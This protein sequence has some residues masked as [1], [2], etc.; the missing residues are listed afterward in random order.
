MAE[1][2]QVRAPSGLI[3]RAETSPFSGVARNFSSRAS[4]AM[5]GV[6]SGPNGW[7]KQKQ[8]P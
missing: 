1:D 8:T 2:E 6:P 5:S 3:S 7:V 4:W